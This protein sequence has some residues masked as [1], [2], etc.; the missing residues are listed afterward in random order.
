VLQRNKSVWSARYEVFGQ[1]RVAGS[2]ES[3]LRFPGQYYDHESGLHQNW[4]REY[5]AVTG[6]YTQFDP[7]ETLASYAQSPW[8]GFGRSLSENYSYSSNN[9]VTFFDPSG[10]DRVPRI[11]T[12][13]PA[14]L[15]PPSMPTPTPTPRRPE[16]YEG[17][18]LIKVLS[19]TVQPTAVAED[20]EYCAEVCRKS[21]CVGVGCLYVTTPR[22]GSR[23]QCRQGPSYCNGGDEMVCPW[24]NHGAKFPSFS[25]VFRAQRQ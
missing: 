21:N 1:A 3:N 5:E 9:P 4:W 16:S 24:H 19:A 25:Q 20:M 23:V 8:P 6:Y 15:P 17:Y 18:H 12:V 11:P 2:F 7:L 22:R 14:P 10:L 13:P